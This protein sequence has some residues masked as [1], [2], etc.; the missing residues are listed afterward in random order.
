MRQHRSSPIFR[1]DCRAGSQRSRF[2]QADFCSNIVYRSERSQPL[3]RLLLAALSAAAFSDAASPVFADQNEDNL[4]AMYM[5]RASNELCDF[6]LSEVE[7][8]KL[9][10]AA[11]F[12]E[13]K[14][15]FDAAA[16]DA[17]Y[18][19]VK[20]AFEGQKADLCKPDGE[21]RKTYGDALSG[22]PE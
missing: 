16:A 18:S 19:K 2:N 20:T 21:W 11:T 1:Q 10:K 9:K 17:F 22:L 15:G 12:L 4:Q 7:A 13:G 6:P 5:L 8:A 3:K 14:I